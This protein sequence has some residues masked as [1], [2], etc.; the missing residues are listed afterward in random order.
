MPFK[1]ISYQEFWQP[2]CLW[3]E[4]IYAILVMI[5]MRNNSLKL[6][7]EFG[8]VVQMLFKRFIWSSGSPP[9]QWSGAIYAILKEGSMGN[10]HV[11]LYSNLDQWFKMSFKEKKY[12]RRL[13]TIA[14]FRLRLR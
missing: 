14:Y 5:I 3:S 6:F 10:N 8:P 1:D 12:R 2:F 7:F 4:T 13:I 11:K 9:V